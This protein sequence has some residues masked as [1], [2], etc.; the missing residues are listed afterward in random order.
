MGLLK[1]NLI[2]I[3]GLVLSITAWAGKPVDFSGLQTLQGEPAAKEV[4]A[5][6]QPSAKKRLLYFWASWCPDCKDKINNHLPAMHG[7]DDVEVLLVNTDKNIDRARHFTEKN[8]VQPPV[9]ADQAKKVRKQFGVFSVP[10]W[11]V[12][13]HDSQSGKWIVVDSQPGSD[14]DRL[15]AALK[16]KE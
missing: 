3:M 6:E 13:T 12:V 11:A 9:F 7:K 15:Q 10:H 4:G 8:N 5:A 2:M 14:L 16:S 1:T